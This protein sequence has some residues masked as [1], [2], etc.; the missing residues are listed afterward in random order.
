MASRRFS[1]AALPTRG[2]RAVAQP[3]REDVVRRHAGDGLGLVVRQQAGDRGV[4]HERD[5]EEEG[6]H[7][8]ERRRPQAQGCVKLRGFRDGNK[9]QWFFAVHDCTKFLS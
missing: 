4:D 2:P 8:Y 7:R 6:E 1:S 9:R 5:Q 3:L